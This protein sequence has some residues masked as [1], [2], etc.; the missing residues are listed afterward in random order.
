MITEL[1]TKSQVTIPKDIV[2]KL[3]LNRGDK[4]EI[5]EKK[6]E[7]HI[8]PVAVYP[9][10]YINSVLEEV[11]EIKSKI[12]SENYPVFDDIDVLLSKLEEN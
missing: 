9:K 11:K 3:G 6:G 4:L 1:R 8:M 12:K 7:I 5:Y 10:E 2:F